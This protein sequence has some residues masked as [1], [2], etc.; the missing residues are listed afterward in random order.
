MLPKRHNLLTIGGVH[1]IK[2]AAYALV[3][4]SRN[5][6]R[7]CNLPLAIN[8]DVKKPVCNL[9]F[10]GH[11]KQLNHRIHFLFS[12][13][14]RFAIVINCGL[15]QH[16]FTAAKLKKQTLCNDFIQTPAF[17]RGL[18]SIPLFQNMFELSQT[19][20]G[21]NVDRVERF[22]GNAQASILFREADRAA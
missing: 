1:F 9:N 22:I 16:N 13:V 2:G 6:R 7:V 3:S 18:G 5:V 21:Q 12:L 17:T 4:S 11:G 10:W 8:D 19:A 20:L 15:A 14:G